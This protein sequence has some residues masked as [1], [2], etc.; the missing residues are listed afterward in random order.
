MAASVVSNKVKFKGDITLDLFDST[1]IDDP[2]LVRFTDLQVERDPDE[3]I[4]IT[5][6]DFEEAY[7]KLSGQITTPLQVGKVFS[8]QKGLPVYFPRDIFEEDVPLYKVILEGTLSSTLPFFFELK[9]I[10]VNPGITCT[11][12]KRRI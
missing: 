7:F 9:D 5:V 2:N 1:A 3:I 10:V 4:D 11:W 8:A 6:S 12:D